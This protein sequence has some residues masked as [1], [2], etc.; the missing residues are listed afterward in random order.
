LAFYPVFPLPFQLKHDAQAEL[1]ALM[2]TCEN[3]TVY[4]IGEEVMKIRGKGGVNCQMTLRDKLG[5]EP[6]VMLRP[7]PPTSAVGNYTINQLQEVSTQCH[8]F[9]V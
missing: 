3:Q 4:I 9:R 8:T 7:V 2:W 6:G 1:D 5:R